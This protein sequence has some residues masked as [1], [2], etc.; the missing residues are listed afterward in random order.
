MKIN[1]YYGGRGVLEDP[2]LYVLDKIE[3]VLSE[4]P[5]SVQRYNIY[6]SKNNISILPQTLVD[7]DG[8][9]L[10]TT[11]EWLGIGGYMQ[12][13]L[14]ACWLYA[15]KNRLGKIFMMP[16]VM[17]TAYGEREAELTLINAWETLG[18][19]PCMGLT[20]YVED[21]VKFKT[22][23]EY[24]AIIENKA[25][26]LYRVISKKLKSLPTSNQMV[27]QTVLKT[28]QL[29]L[30]PEEGQKLSEYVSDDEYVEQQKNDIAELSK[31]YKDKIK[32]S[33]PSDNSSYI[34]AFK[35]RFNSDVIADVDY[36]FVIDGIKEPLAVRVHRGT[37]VC[38]FGE[39]DKPDIYVKISPNA[40]EK[41]LS[42][43]MTFQ[44]TFMEG[45]LR[46]QGDFATFRRLDEF[47]DTS[48]EDK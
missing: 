44:R 38:E 29:E 30:T 47:F 37:L 25:E 39:I 10:A 31:I 1:I 26:N 15:D 11:V 16:V 36:A 17:S 45:S 19:M 34:D 41:V 3:Q 9:I 24:T 35:A 43:H 18:G 8:I 13:F 48:I 21:L 2:T 7:V 4:L 5:V 22:N 28:S 46:A 23:S 12:Q 27:S 14:D 40:L 32:A 42:G 6:E 33:R 20:G